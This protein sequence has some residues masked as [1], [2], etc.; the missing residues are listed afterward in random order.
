M[1]AEQKFQP[2]NSFVTFCAVR[3]ALSSTKCANPLRGPELQV[4]LMLGGHRYAV[5]KEYIHYGNKQ[6]FIF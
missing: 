1:I 6:H 3:S 4:K 2:D 5:Q